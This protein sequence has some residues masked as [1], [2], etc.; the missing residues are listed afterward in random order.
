MRS[1]VAPPVAPFARRLLSDDLPD[2]ADDRLEEAIA[3]VERR[4]LTLPSVMR[5]GVT[6]LAVVFR[7]ILAL[8]GGWTIARALLALPLPFVPEYPRLVRSLA[9]A[10]VWETWPSTTSTGAAAPTVVGR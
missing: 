5:L 3:F 2:L 10:Y 7:G 6:V 8:P 1:P 4:L 9:Y